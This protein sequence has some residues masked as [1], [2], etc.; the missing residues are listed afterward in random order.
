MYGGPSLP[1]KKN[2]N[3]KNKKNKSIKNENKEIEQMKKILFRKNPTKLSWPMI[4]T[5]DKKIFYSKRKKKR[6]IT[7]A[8]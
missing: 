4:A 1:I 2:K 8:P 5:S 6:K 7:M 3:K